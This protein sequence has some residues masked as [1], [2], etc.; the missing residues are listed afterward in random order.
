MSIVCAYITLHLCIIIQHLCMANYT[1][2]RVL[3]G[4][5]CPFISPWYFDRLMSPKAPVN[6]C[7]INWRS[8]YDNY[9]NF[10]SE[11][12]FLTSVKAK[13]RED[14]LTDPLT[15]RKKSHFNVVSLELSH[16]TIQRNWSFGVTHCLSQDAR[17]LIIKTISMGAELDLKVGSKKDVEQQVPI[18]TSLKC[19]LTG[20]I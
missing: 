6:A 7:L 10:S 20:S 4:K 9:Y 3:C 18:A 15:S 8:H 14:N 12:I 5:R 1:S 19:S 17:L 2:A 16:G 11:T 13:W